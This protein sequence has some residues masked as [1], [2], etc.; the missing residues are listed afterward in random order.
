M[1]TV[2]PYCPVS[3]WTKAGADRLFRRFKAWGIPDL[4]NW[5]LITLTVDRNEYPDAEAAFELGK[6]YV[7][8]F[9]T[10][11][12]ATYPHENHF[13]KLELHQPDKDDGQVYPHWH[14]LVDWKQQVDF[15]VVAAMWR[16]GRLKVQRVEDGDCDYLFKYV[17]KSVDELP[18]WLKKRRTV[19]AWSASKGFFLK[20]PP[21]AKK[22]TADEGQVLEP[23]DQPE[24]YIEVADGVFARDVPAE[25]N[26]SA[27]LGERL[28]KWARTVQITEEQADGS[29]R[30][31]LRVTAFASWNQFLAHVAQEKLTHL[32]GSS[33]LTIKE[34]E[35]ECLKI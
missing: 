20:R 18:E 25:R 8:D 22:G 5:R 12:K 11:F 13:T 27:T 23:Y 28:E 3:F 4:R 17:A 34:K 31:Y 10:A 9:R 26:E 1:I 16:M 6:L 14:L 33:D 2:R 29:I 32:L 35:I 24:D 7:S 30:G 19:R 21:T 15:V